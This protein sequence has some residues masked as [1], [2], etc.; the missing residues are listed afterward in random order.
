MEQRR[1]ALRCYFVGQSV[2]WVFVKLGSVK[3]VEQ[4]KVVSLVVEAST[5]SKMMAQELQ[6]ELEV[7]QE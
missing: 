5:S 7:H 2:Y 6:I 1:L 3:L 4:V